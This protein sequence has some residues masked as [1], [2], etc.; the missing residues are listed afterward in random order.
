MMNHL[1]THKNLLNLLVAFAVL[2]STLGFASAA[3]AQSSC[4][5]TYIVQR[6]DYLS[7]IARTCG[8]T[9]SNLL[10]ANPTI[11][12]PSLIYP[13]QVINIPTGTV[14]VTGSKPGDY[15]V[16]K[17]DTLFSI[18]Q[19]YTLTEADLRAA[20]PNLG[21][22]INIGQVLRIPSRITFATGG[23]AASIQGQLGANSSHYYLLN[24]AAEQTL[25]VTVTGPSDLTFS[26]LGADGSTVK[27]AN[28]LPGFRGVLPKT[29]DYILVLKSANSTANYGMSLSI[30]QRI[31]FASGGTSATLTGTVPAALSQ[32]FVLRALKGQTMTVTTTPNDKL[33]LT[34]YGVDGTVL[35]S[36]M[37]E[38]ASF[39]GVLP[40]T[41]D[42]ILV[43][44]SA[45]QVQTFSMTVSIPPAPVPV[46][47]TGSY[48]VQ[49][50]DTLFSIASRFGTTVSVLMRANPDITNSS[51]ISVGQVIY[52]PGA[53]ITLANGQKVYIAKR[54]DTMSAIARQF[55]KTLDALINANQQIS[56]PN[57]ILTGQRINI[58]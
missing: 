16:V 48:T 9:Y 37:G 33:Q 12:N 57:V 10:K 32:Y 2:L 51:V 4:G 56:N 25:E 21:T 47:G 52:L 39:T 55:S 29:Q 49:K 44:K 23:T 20:N 43:L 42:Y 11:K 26:I 38:G 34:V 14:P 31:R 45:N 53:T 50:G 41:Q 6:G 24:A 3:A 40:S 1:L 18:A 15:T 35:K 54:G 17:G 58:P 8:V 46:T 7:K 19:R 13:G 30:P 27:S 5:A 36:P 22:T 28:N